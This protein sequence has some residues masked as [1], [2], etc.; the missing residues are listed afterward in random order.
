MG[1]TDL[2]PILIDMFSE[3]GNITILDFGCGKGLFVKDLLDEGYNAYGCDFI[4]EI[5]DISK[6]EMTTLR[7]INENPYKLPFND[8]EFDFVVSTEVFEHVMD[9]K[10]T[11]KE[12]HRILKP[13]GISLNTFPG[14]YKFIESHVLVPLASILKNKIW[15][16]LWAYLGIRNQFQKGK[17]AQEVAE[18]NYRYLHAHTNYLTQSQIRRYANFFSDVKFNDDVFALTQRVTIKHGTLIQTEKTEK[19]SLFSPT[20][21]KKIFSRGLISRAYNDYCDIKWKLYK[22]LYHHFRVRVLYLKK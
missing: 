8:N 17:S 16:L 5:G 6:S 18:L 15:L 7:I 2:I 14:K 10:T 11:L 12:I 19:P 3:E 9:Y 22:K 13:G 4:E 1:K 20:R 21:L